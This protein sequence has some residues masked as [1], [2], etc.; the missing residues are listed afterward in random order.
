MIDTSIK[1]ALKVM[2]TSICT[3]VQNN[4]I[5]HSHSVEI[6]GLREEGGKPQ[7]QSKSSTVDCRT[8]SHE[9]AIDKDRK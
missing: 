3:A 2:Q 5:I 7:T 8:R 1:D 6:K 9:E 4:P